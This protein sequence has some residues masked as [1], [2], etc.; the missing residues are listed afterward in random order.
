[1][2]FEISKSMTYR[3]WIVTIGE[4]LPIDAGEPRLLRA[5]IIA[6]MLADAGHDVT[7]WTA[8]FDHQKKQKRFPGETERI[9]QSG[10]RLILL[11]ASP[12]SRN[13]SIARV[14]NHRR[15]ASAFTRRSASEARPDVILCSF[16]PIEL[17]RE[18]AIFG[19][20]H[21]V[22]TVIDIRDLWPDVMVDLA[23]KS[24]RWLA[25][26]V[27]S[28]MRRDTV[29]T[30]S[31][32][33]AVIGVTDEYRNWGLAQARRN[34]SD[35]DRTFPFA[36]VDET[37]SETSQSAARDFWRSHGVGVDSNAFVVAFFG[38]IG[39]QFDLA[40]VIR[41]AKLLDD[42]KLP[43]KFV[44]CGDGESLARYRTMAGDLGSVLFPGWVNAT[45]IWTLMRQSQVGLGPYV[46]SENFRKN[47]PNKIIEYLSA[48]LPPVT[49]LRG[50]TKEL[51]QTN[52]CGYY[53]QHGSAEELVR[54]IDETIREPAGLQQRSRNA[55]SLFE[56]SFAA[57]RVYSDLIQFLGDL[58]ARGPKPRLTEK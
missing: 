32:A 31:Q 37:P 42:Q 47:I 58:A 20:R 51:L 26:L 33:T 34:A 15:I 1:V 23:P 28:R 49:C 6:K 43:A 27:L 38:T 24:L 10:L 56:R 46:D 29:E 16:P 13:I 39:R 48:G 7:W 54:I 9:V 8:N 40:T 45:Q 12:Y 11:D 5:G 55:R 4:P 2:E 53:Y 17:A 3:I 52:D 30:M 35:Y 57:E 21:N 36:Y 14:L 18:V 22:P 19:R 41:A 44:L 25:K 50:A